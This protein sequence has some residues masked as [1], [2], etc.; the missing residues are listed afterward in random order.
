MTCNIK[1]E[2][3]KFFWDFCNKRTHNRSKMRFFKFYE[4]ITW[5]TFV[6]FLRKVTIAYIKA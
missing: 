4:K 5:R 6:N 1:R 2:K 3:K